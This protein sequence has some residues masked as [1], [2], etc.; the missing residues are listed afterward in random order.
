M[1][2]SLEEKAS[3]P[4]HNDFCELI[5]IFRK[6]KPPLSKW[7]SY[8]LYI[9]SFLAMGLFL[10]TILGMSSSSERREYSPSRY[11]KVVKEGILWDSV[12]WHER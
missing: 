12:E 9:L 2:K 8:P 3:F 6:D 10:A 11:R 5:N 7:L 1:E 4:T